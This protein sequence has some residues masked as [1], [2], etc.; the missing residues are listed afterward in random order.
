MGKSDNNHFRKVDLGIWPTQN[1]FSF[2]CQYSSTLPR[3]LAWLNSLT[4]WFNSVIWA[5]TFTRPTNNIGIFPKSIRKNE[6][7]LRRAHRTCFFYFSINVTTATTEKKESTVAKQIQMTANWMYFEV[8]FC[9]QFCMKSQSLN[10]IEMCV[11]TEIV[12]NACASM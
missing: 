4:K 7:N 11:S 6:N 12:W 3:A 8:S 2:V 1:S 10:D 5:W 9:L